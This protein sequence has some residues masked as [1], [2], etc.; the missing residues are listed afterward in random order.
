GV[1]TA[2]S[3]AVYAASGRNDAGYLLFVRD[4]ALMAQ[5]FDT[6]HLKLAGEPIPIAERVARDPNFPRGNFSVSESGVLLYD[7]SVNRQRKEL[8][9]VDREGKPIG[10]PPVIGGWANPWLS[11]D[12]KRV[13]VDRIDYEMDTRQ[14]WL[15]ER[16]GGS[17]TRFTFDPADDVQ[18]VWSP[19]GS[20]IV[21]G[22]SRE[23]IPD[24]Y[25]KAASGVGRDELLLKSG[26]LKV[27][28]DWSQDGRFIIFY[29]VDAKTKRDIWVL[30]LDSKEPFPFL[31]TEANEAGGRLSPD[32][33]WMAYSSDETGNYEVY[34]QSFPRGGGKRQVSSKGGV[35]PH[36]RHDGKELFYYSA[37]GKL[38]TAEIKTGESFEGSVP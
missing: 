6:G 12:E 15:Q 32:G 5:P 3:N 27:P 24:L 20:R 34:V 26:Y 17:G 11:P 36:W 35:G 22:S 9:W 28:T 16:A 10:T 14:L 19:D 13:V 21:W 30:P 25:W 38:M 8:V 31:Q 2:G 1:P 37:D 23:G 29:Q 33:K 18:P 4:D 7:G